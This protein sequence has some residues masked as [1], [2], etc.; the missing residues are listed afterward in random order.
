MKRYWRINWV[1]F[2]NSII[3]DSKMPGYIISSILLRIL[4]IL[5]SILFFNI[6]FHFTDNLAGWNF[7][8]VLFLYSFARIISV[9]NNGWTRKGIMSMSDSLIRRGEFDFYLAKPVDTMLMVSI[10]KPRLYNF[11]TLFFLIP[12]AVYAVVKS[13]IEIN[14]I[15]VFW[16]LFLSIFSLIL[17][18]FLQVLTVVPAFWF[19]RL[20]SLRDVINRLAMFMRYPAGVFSKNIRF[21]LMVLFPI[22]TVSYIPSQA[23]FYPPQIKYIIY[24][25][26]ITL[27]FAFLT[28]L[29]WYIGESKYSSASS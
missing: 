13:G 15:N 21:A 16:F 9:I 5:I 2:K 10:S 18:Y 19:V 8:Q 3:R 24:M 25:L 4:D 7:Y 1:L 12:T 23:L 27:F 14:A 26:I 20:W 6:I 17:Y 11:L 29:L 28:K 22:I